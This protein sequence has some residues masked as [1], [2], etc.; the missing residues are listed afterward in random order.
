MKI[1]FDENRIGISDPTIN[2]IDTNEVV[3]I[4]IICEEKIQIKAN[5]DIQMNERI[6]N[7]NNSINRREKVFPTETPAIFSITN[8]ISK[9]ATIFIDAIKIAI[10][11]KKTILAFDTS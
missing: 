9:P 11:F 3:T 10:C 6:S 1:L 4:A 8:E 7:E 5:N 2:S